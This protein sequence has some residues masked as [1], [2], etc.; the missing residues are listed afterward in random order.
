[1]HK[2]VSW[3]LD[4]AVGKYCTMDTRPKK[5]KFGVMN[6]GEIPGWINKADGDPWDVFA[7]G[8][9]NE[10]KT[11]SLYKIHSII[12]VYFLENG[13]HKIAVRLHAPGFDANKST[14]DVKNYCRNYS[15]F[16]KVKG[17]YLEIK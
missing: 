4:N 5:Y 1:M 12:G 2:K 6:Y 16:T 15:A 14:R 17:Q 11:N 10:L 13:N 9:H 8:Y 7:P 3:V